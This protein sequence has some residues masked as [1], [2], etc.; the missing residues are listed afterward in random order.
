MTAMALETMASLITRFRLA[1]LPP[2]VLVTVPSDAAKTMDFHRAAE[3]IAIGRRLT[4]AALDEAFADEDA[5]PQLGSG[6][7]LPE[8]TA[9]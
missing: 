9:D 7:P 2:D 6:V 4:E 3:L 5:Q 8:L 1:T